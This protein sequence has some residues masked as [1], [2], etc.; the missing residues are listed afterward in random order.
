MIYVS[1]ALSL[2]SLCTQV[3]TVR[4]RTNAVLTLQPLSADDSEGIALALADT[5]P[6]AGL[7]QVQFVAVDNPSA[8]YYG[9]LQ[10]ICPN[11]Q[12]M[13]LDPVH[14]AMTMEYAS[15]RKRTAGSKTLRSVLAKLTALDSTRAAGTWGRFFAG[16]E[17]RQLTLEE[18]R[19]RN[20][21][22]ASS[23][24]VSTA[25]NILE[26]LDPSVPFYL[27]VEWVRI[28]AALSAVFKA[29]VQRVAKG[30]NKRVVQ[31]LY[32]AASPTRIE[33]YW[34][35]L[36][37]R[38]ALPRNII[39]LLPIGTTS[40]ESLHREINVWFRETQKLLHATVALKLRILKL[41]KNISHNAALYRPTTRQMLQAEVLHLAVC[42][43]GKRGR[44]GALSY[45]RPTHPECRRLNCRW[46]TSVLS[47]DLL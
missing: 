2:L 19:L 17:C 38:H 18:T 30:P 25:K 7:A 12:A 35:N 6:A 20:Q 10:K 21:I 23:M 41:S 14:L 34:N 13:C 11:L 24:R 42:F 47:K 5:I 40:N 32:A 1:C 8:K 36:R 33:W 27:Q 26:K 46:K 22:E 37:V 3:L 31:L 15:S 29:E 43:L 28:L 9:Q 45:F 4:G 39:P 16:Q 44:G